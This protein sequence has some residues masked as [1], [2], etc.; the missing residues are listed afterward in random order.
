VLS[1]VFPLSCWV[2]QRRLVADIRLK[3][4]W[5]QTIQVI[6]MQMRDKNLG[7]D[8]RRDPGEFELAVGSLADVE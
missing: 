8:R 5:H 7:D 4:D 2:F 1:L 6:T 3:N